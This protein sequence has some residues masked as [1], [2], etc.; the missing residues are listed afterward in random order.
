MEFEAIKFIISLQR[1]YPE[2]RCHIV[3]LSAADALPLIRQA[4][5]E[6]MNLTV[7]T[8]FHYLSF[9]AEDI[10]LGRPDFKCCPPIRD[11]KNRELLWEAIID[12]TIDF[13]VSDHSPCVAELKKLEEG[14]FMD[15]WG[16]ISGLGLGLHLL[17]EE[18]RRRG[19]SPSRIAELLSEKPAEHAGLAGVKGR[20][21]P[22]YDADLVIWDPE[23]ST[24][25]NNPLLLPTDYS[26]SDIRHS[27]WVQIKKG[28]LE[29]KNKVSPY[30]GLTL[31]GAVKG[32]ILRGRR[33]WTSENGFG[34]EPRPRGHFI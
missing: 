2:L 26:L 5:K 7:E 3:H 15:A 31:K 8:A 23:G 13:V 32:T 21:A 33:V 6:G 1:S 18:A 28:M 27:V 24:Q 12:G 9:V 14:N 20:I 25:V 17:W 10:P 11:K 29:F 16:G 22:G 30:T 19:L 34:C 4:K